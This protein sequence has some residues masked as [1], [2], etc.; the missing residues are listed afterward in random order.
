MNWFEFTTC[1]LKTNISC[2][3]RWSC[4]IVILSCS[5]SFRTMQM[6]WWLFQKFCLKQTIFACNTFSR[7]KNWKNVVFTNNENYA[8]DLKRFTI[9]IFSNILSVSKFENN[10]F[11][12]IAMKICLA[13]I[14]SFKIFENWVRRLFDVFEFIRTLNRCK[15]YILIY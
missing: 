1:F 8:N 3:S 2:C 15:W 9:L 4:A 7:N 12:F 6:T 13:N 14:L 5:S 11:D 10:K